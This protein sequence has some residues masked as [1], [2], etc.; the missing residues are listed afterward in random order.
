MYFGYVRTRSLCDA[1]SLGMTRR[2][3]TESWVL[4]ISYEESNMDNSKRS[5]G[6]PGPGGA[7]ACVV[8]LDSTSE[9]S[10]EVWSAA[11]NRANRFITNNQA[12]YCGLLTG[13]RVGHAHHWSDLESRFLM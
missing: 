2:S 12:E 10:S 4:H 5:R 6:N 11:T 1:K 13:T 8:R 9:I 3:I 7:D